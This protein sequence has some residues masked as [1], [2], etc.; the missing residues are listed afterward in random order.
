MIRT[1]EEMEADNK[2]FSP[3]GQISF[4]QALALAIV[5]GDYLRARR[6]RYPLNRITI[7]DDDVEVNLDYFEMEVM[8]QEPNGNDQTNARDLFIYSHIS[9]EYIYYVFNGLVEYL[10]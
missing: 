1:S 3:L 9:D 4:Q 2:L 6:R 7:G 10:E 8:Y 5:A